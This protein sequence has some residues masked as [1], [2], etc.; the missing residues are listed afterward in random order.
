MTNPTASVLIIGNEILSGRTLDLNTQ[1]IAIQLD[2]IG[3]TLL[4]SRTIPDNKTAIIDNVKELSEKYDY[5]LTTGG[6]GPTHDDITAQSIADAFGVK[7]ERNQEIYDILKENHATRG[8][9][10]NSAREKMAYVPE[11]S[12]L[13]HN[14]ATNI[15][16]FAIKN[17]FVM[18]GIPYVMKSMLKSV[19]PLLKR[20]KIIKSQSLEIMISESE[21]ADKF[22]EIQNKYI[23]VEMGSYPFTKHKI[24]GTVLVLR[25]SNY[26]SLKRSFD[27]LKNL[28]KDN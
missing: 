9:V 23:D 1:E 21:I 19:L 4:E 2:K 10:L 20:G 17:V 13:L 8:Q 22:E 24:Y 11:S 28:F 5:V 25:S 3:V 16:G 15:P 7:Y 26:N 14:E 18:A 27:E 6:I 12:I